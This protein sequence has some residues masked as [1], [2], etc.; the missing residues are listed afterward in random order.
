L[1]CQNG[2]APEREAF[3]TFA[4]FDAATA[5]V[6]RSTFRRAD[7]DRS[8]ALSASEFEDFYIWLFNPSLAPTP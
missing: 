2:A 1:H 6:C 4:D 8:T 7:H 3:I 5:S